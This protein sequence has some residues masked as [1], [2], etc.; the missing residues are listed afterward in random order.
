[1]EER[2][3][4]RSERRNER[5]LRHRL[6]RYLAWL[7]LPLAFLANLDAWLQG[8]T[9]TLTGGTGGDTGHE[10]WFLGVIAH[11]L[12]HLHSPFFTDVVNAPHGVNLANV[13]SMPVLGMLCAPLT[14]LFGP[15]LSYNVLTVISTLSAALAMYWA[16]GR[17]VSNPFARFAAG[18]LYGFSPYMAAQ[19][20]GHL[21]LTTVFVFPVMVVALHELLVRQTWSP[22]ITG[23]L[24]TLCLIFQIGISPELLLD[25]CLIAVLPV[26]LL[27]VALV[28][29]PLAATVYATKSLATAVGFAAI[30]VGI[31]LFEF[32]CGQG[33]MTGAYR[34]ASSVNHLKMDVL[35][36]LF[37]SSIQ[38]FGLGLSQTID[39]YTYI[40][41][42]GVIPD[43]FETGGYIGIPMLLLLLASLSCWWKMKEAW[44]LGLGAVVSVVISLGFQPSLAGRPL[45]IK[46][47]FVLL[48]HLPLLESSI[49]SRWTLFLWLFLALLVAIAVDRTW[50]VLK[51]LPSSHKKTSLTYGAGLMV[52]AAILSLIP[53]WPMDAQEAKVPHW[54]QSDAVNQLTPQ[55]LV[56]TSPLPINGAPLAM[57]WQSVSGFRFRLAYGSAGPQTSTWTA[58]KAIVTQC[59]VPHAPNI[60]DLTRLTEAQQELRTL[61]VTKLIATSLDTN[62]TCG[63]IVFSALAGTPGANEDDVR[64]WDLTNQN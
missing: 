45:G 43:R 52:V 28:R 16:A 27:L 8:P 1:M 40:L 26:S 32:L 14:W 64:V 5:R 46:G 62:P 4:S 29:R 12:R 63:R 33:H 50:A 60:P 6:H 7:Y 54:F 19:L 24:L 42:P 37:P 51:T 3:S 35:S 49:A 36:F 21:F 55:D 23:G 39:A 25:A 9:H 44:V 15:I 17:F 48:Q 56:V 53:S 61:G 47:P 13:T 41:T 22:R 34:A 2:P 38:H 18:L 11:Q 59:D 57:L 30:P 31:F 20:W 58:V 10:I